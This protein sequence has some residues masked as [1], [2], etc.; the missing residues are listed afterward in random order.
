MGCK[1]DRTVA[2]FD[3]EP[4]GGYET[5][6]GE[7][8]AR[9][10]GEDGHEARGYRTLTEWFNER[11]LT[12]VYDDNGRGTAGTRVSSDYGALTG[13]DESLRAEVLAD[14]RA[15]GIDA[16]AVD[17][18]LVSWST[19]RT[20]LTGCLD[21]SKPATGSASDWERRSVEIATER[22]ASKVR[23]AVRSLASKGEITGADDAS[24]AVEAY[25]VCP[26]CELR[27]PVSRARDRGYVCQDHLGGGRDSR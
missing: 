25:L 11:L 16:D 10:T 7:L 2:A 3:L 8:L 17:A 15:D 1:V 4:T 18:A 24:I 14:L 22:T 27:V 23:D 26:E 21:G 5:I 9:W 20:H 13:D 19:M 12:Q 6:D